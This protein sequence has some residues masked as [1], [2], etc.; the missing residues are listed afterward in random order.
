MKTPES[1]ALLVDCGVIQEVRRPLMS[2]KEAQVYVV[3]AGGKECV[4]KV[5][6]EANQRTFKHRAE[7][8]E[9]RRSRNTRDQRAVS[10]RT[11]HG[12]KRDEAAWRSTEVDM[13]FR[14]RDAGVSVPEPIIFVDGVL[15]MELV[16]DTHKNPAP[17]LGDLEFEASE[18]EAIYQ[19]LIRE[20]VRMLC[21][22]VVHGDLSEFNVL[23]SAKGPVVID[24]PQA[25]DPAH[26]RNARNLLLRDVENLHR[27][28][29]RYAPKRSTLRYAEEMWSLYESNRLA[30]DTEMRGDY[31]V[32]EST[33]DTA[34]VLLL[35][36]EANQEEQS[37]RAARGEERERES[38]AAPAQ[39]SRGRRQRRRKSSAAPNTRFELSSGSSA[40]TTTSTR[41]E[42]HSAQSAAPKMHRTTSKKTVAP[43]EPDAAK[44]RPRR[45]QTA[46]R[47][48][49][50][51]SKPGA[52]RGTTRQ[53]Q[54]K[55][56]SAIHDTEKPRTATD[57]AE[58]PRRRR[59][60]RPRAKGA[61]P[62]LRPR[63]PNYE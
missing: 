46:G 27:F 8:T 38:A 21:A 26:N 35:I 15:V 53:A 29:E 48:R 42:A 31:R 3:L 50:D 5:Y 47:T 61:H 49:I 62:G 23:M 54:P 4:A 33:V 58:A 43:S 36:D 24:F 7:Y 11:Q 14:L 16:K 59:R 60:R 52:A 28:A 22:G 40:V 19:Q 57:A 13:I 44:R 1:L 20:V 17:R 51:N 6:K 39:K 63:T 41:R 18:I 12:R 30:P 2:G 37:R 10:K 25:V 9:G 34:E 56:G 32:P 45:R 55:T